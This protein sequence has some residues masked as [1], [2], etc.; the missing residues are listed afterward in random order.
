MQ[1]ITLTLHLLKDMAPPQPFCTQCILQ[2]VVVEIRVNDAVVVI[3]H[4][5]AFFGV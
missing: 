1:P 4:K 5:T 2:R 3:G